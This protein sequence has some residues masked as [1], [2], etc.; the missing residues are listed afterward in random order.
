M[1][2]Q[3]HELLADAVNPSAW[4]LPGVAVHSRSATG[5]KYQMSL[6]P[7]SDSRRMDRNWAADMTTPVAAATQMVC[8]SARM[9]AATAARAATSSFVPEA[10]ARIHA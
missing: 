8:R 3:E 2:L 7:A 5:L 4:A 10:L 1:A 9:S 6:R